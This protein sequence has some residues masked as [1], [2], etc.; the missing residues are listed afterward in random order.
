M[1]TAIR[2]G[3]RAE[4]KDREPTLNPGIFTGKP[5]AE[6]LE[7][8]VSELLREGGYELTKADLR[9]FRWIVDFFQMRFPLDAV[10]VAP[11]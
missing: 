5:I 10:A 9:S 1:H 4:N 3:R 7:T 6:K 2:R 8:T 11:L